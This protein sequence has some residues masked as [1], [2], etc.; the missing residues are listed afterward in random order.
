METRGELLVRDPYGAAVLDCSK[1][2]R[3]KELLFLRELFAMLTGC[4]RYSYGIFASLYAFH[5]RFI[6]DYLWVFISFAHVTVH[7][8]KLPVC[9]PLT[10]LMYHL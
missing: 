10:A 5:A 3:R 6:R 9:L 8:R 7:P 4:M 1:I 2:D